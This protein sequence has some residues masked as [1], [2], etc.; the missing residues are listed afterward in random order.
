[1]KFS[2]SVEKTANAGGLYFVLN[3]PTVLRLSPVIGQMQHLELNFVIKCKH[4]FVLC[5]ETSYHA[6]MPS[7][8][9][10]GKFNQLYNKYQY[11]HS[12]DLVIAHFISCVWCLA[13]VIPALG[14][15]R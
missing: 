15:L 3:P 13:P 8:V 12:P 2:K 4:R 9:E 7:N 10:H 1:M 6:S 14:R 5:I 11:T